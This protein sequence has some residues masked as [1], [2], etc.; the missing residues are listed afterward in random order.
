MKYSLYMLTSSTENTSCPTNTKGINSILMIF[1]T[2]IPRTME[3][4]STWPKSFQKLRWRCVV[5]ETPVVKSACD[6]ARLTKT[7]RN[8][9]C[10]GDQTS[11]LTKKA[12]KILCDS[13]DDDLRMGINRQEIDYHF[14]RFTSMP[15][16]IEYHIL[17][18][19]ISKNN[20]SDFEKRPKI[21]AF[22]NRAES[23]GNGTISASSRTIG[24]AIDNDAFRELVSSYRH[25]A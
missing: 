13:H 19:N 8:S 4:F 23:R 2:M 9:Y 18:A 14:S 1:F 11:F 3:A 10:K 6:S 5:I 7:Q 24:S 15:H 16:F 25:R 22:P 12:N 17:L 21:G 20:S